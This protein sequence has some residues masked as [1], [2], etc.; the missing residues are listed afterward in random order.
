MS[1]WGKFT[2]FF[3][4]KYVDKNKIKPKG[5]SKVR[6]SADKLVPDGSNS[7]GDKLKKR[8]KKMNE[9]LKKV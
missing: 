7:L 2:G 4:K 8:R 5:K 6:E 1:A 3:I 9:A